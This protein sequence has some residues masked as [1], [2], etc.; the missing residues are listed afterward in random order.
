MSK[1]EK[2]ISRFLANPKDFTWSELQHLLGS[3]DYIELQGKG[4]RVKFYHKTLDSLIQLHKPHP[5][6]IVKAYVIREIKQILQAE[7]LL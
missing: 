4:S 1:Q 6:K 7:N 3:L 2:L 5:A